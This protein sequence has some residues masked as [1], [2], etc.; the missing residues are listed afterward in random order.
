MNRDP[1]VV[2]GMPAY[3]RPD[4]LP[5]TLE[6][7]L[8]QTYRDFAL[9]IVDDDPS[10]ETAAIVETYAREYPRVSYEANASRLGMIGNW[11]KAFQ[12]ARKTYPTSPY[13]AWVSDHDVWHARF[14]DE[15]V[16]VLDAHPE[17]VLAY[18]ENLRMMA[19][20]SR[21]AIKVFETVGMTRR[22]DRIR[23]SARHMMA[24]DMIYGLM[25]A[26]ALEA[27][28][29]FRPVIT[30]DRQVLLALSLIGQV[31]QVPEVLWY[32]EM[33]HGFDLKRQ[34]DAFFPGGAP[35]YSYAPSHVQH[36][37]V[38]LWDFAARGRGRPAFGRLAGAYYAMLQ[39]V[40]SVARDV[41]QPKAGWRQAASRL[42]PSGVGRQEGVRDNAA[43]EA[44]EQE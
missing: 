14:L 17:V 5:R 34:R 19:D 11:R 25:R 26:D 4:V 10:P 21:M 1:K 6:S 30:P 18:P 2:L 38:L 35:L 42:R 28:G 12:A 22:T 13:F 37:A 44:L 43:P 29:V 24:G 7:L 41:M 3:S 20:Q 23:I 16:S 32:R 27:A 40:Y 33:R 9:L 39:L 31:K 36:F 8:S 15:M